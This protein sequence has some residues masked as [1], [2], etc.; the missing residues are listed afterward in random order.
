MAR[1]P[2]VQDM[3]RRPTGRP[4]RS[5]ATIQGAG[6]PGAAL[7]GLGQEVTD[8][9]DRI[10][11]REATAAAKER[12][13]YVSDQIRTLLYDPEAGF[14]GKSGRNAVVDRQAA[15]ERLTAI[16]E[17]AKKD[18]NTGASSKLEASLM[19]RMEGARNSIERHT[20]GARSSWMSGASAARIESAA[21]DAIFDPSGT[22]EALA[23]IDSEIAER[24][25]Q[26]GWGSDQ[27]D[28]AL[29]KARSGVYRGQ[30]ERMAQIDPVAALGQ[31][32]DY[33]GEM[34]GADVA[35]LEVQLIPEARAYR[36]R[37]AG[38]AAFN[39]QQIG[40]AMQVA[41]SAVGMSE[42]EQREALQAYMRDGGVNLDPAKTA[43]CAAFI[44]ATLAKAG[45]EGTDSLAA[46]S[47]LDWGQEVSTPQQ[48][49]VV[50]LSRGNEAWQGHVGFFD[51]YNEDG[52]IRLLGGNQGDAVNI[53][54]YDPSRVLGFRRA[55]Q[56]DRT[57]VE[58]LLNIT[59]PDERAAAFQ[60]YNLRTQM[61]DSRQK[62]A[63]ADAEES[64]FAWIE[65]GNSISDLPY[66]FRVN[67]GR[68][69]MS[70][71]LSYQQKKNSGTLQTN[72]S[73]YSDLME[74]YANDPQG[75]AAISPA[76]YRGDLSDGDFKKMVEMR[77]GV[78]QGQEAPGITSVM[79][80]ADAA[81]R[82]SGVTKSDAPDLYGKFQS[83]M[84]GWIDANPDAANDPVALQKR[85]NE[86]LAVVAFDPWGPMNKTETPAF[87]VDFSG[88]PLDPSDDLTLE[89]LSTRLTEIN[90]V[91]VK[92]ETITT[93]INAFQNRFGRS[94]TPQE[95]LDGMISSGLYSR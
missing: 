87:A 29:S 39:G 69:E 52:T 86:Q 94:P 26:E 53:K 27:T 8:I 55:G 67:L 33:R 23:V 37:K 61:A 30:L 65:A 54:G 85:I 95:V 34:M 9:G 7:A 59:D 6:A 20:M 89:Q 32:E 3:G 56:N 40:A 4:Q 63:K 71:L 64:A 74:Q 92:S 13:A 73:R 10:Y 38:E 46:R 72:W 60:E 41:Y 66:D 47:F 75:F 2:T 80:M 36:G 70:G 19:R 35:A 78:M 28:L 62:Q 57:G 5:V 16:E 58:D 51:G 31:L 12:D 21:N 77:T 68:E 49:D 83:Q 11:E 14:M 90:G 1:L 48:G 44:N 76:T 50:V 82:A 43:W 22:Q 84:I 24:A 25:R 42:N 17:A 88:D 79:S 93:F 18:L 45:I 15:L 81:L 91:S